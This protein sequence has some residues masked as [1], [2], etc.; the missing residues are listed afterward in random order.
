MTGAQTDRMTRD[1]GWRLL[2]LG[3]MIERLHTLAAALVHGFETEAVFEDG[4]FGAIVALFDSTITFHAQYQQRRDIPALLDLLVLDRNNPRS[5]GWVTQT[6]RGRLDKLAGSTPGDQPDLAPDL[7]DPGSWALT[8]LCGSAEAGETANEGRPQYEQLTG[9][10]EQ[11]GSAALALSDTLSR[12][13]FSHAASGSH[14]L[15]A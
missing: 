7:P 6:L 15:G 8:E 4:G 2:S 10:L 12:R 1:D 9:L 3:R 14:S 5:L 13:Y 11:C